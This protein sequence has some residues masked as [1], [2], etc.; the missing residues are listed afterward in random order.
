MRAADY[1]IDLGPGASD[2]G[3]QVV[4]TGTPEE[5]VG[6][7]GSHTGQYLAQVLSLDESP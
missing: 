3:G 5:I 4:A 1:I 6:K 2:E 7:P